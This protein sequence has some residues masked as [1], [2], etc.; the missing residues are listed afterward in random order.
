MPYGSET[1]Q[2]Y[3]GVSRRL[4]VTAAALAVSPAGAEE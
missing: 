2:Y 3:P 1:E 4:I